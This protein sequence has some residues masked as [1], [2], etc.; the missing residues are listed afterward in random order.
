MGEPMKYDDDPNEE[1]SPARPEPCCENIKFWNAHRSIPKEAQKGVSYGKR[2]YTTWDA[3]WA[4]REAT[5]LWGPYGENWGLDILSVDMI[6]GANGAIVGMRM[7][8]A[9]FCP[10]AKPFKIVND[11]AYSPTGETL[12]KLQTNTLK[13]AMSMHGWAADLYLGEF[14]DDQDTDP[15]EGSIDK[16]T[17]HEFAAAAVRTL[18]DATSIGRVSYVEK[19]CRDNDLKAYYMQQVLKASHEA[20]VRIQAGESEQ[21]ASDLFGGEDDSDMPASGLS[22]RTD[23]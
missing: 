7:T 16:R 9:F 23:P 17:P 14:D 18:N 6:P 19:E 15:D 12:K 13:K 1:V 10:I 21:E 20:R 11:M 22:P 5:K 2:K 4:K 8:A 3:T